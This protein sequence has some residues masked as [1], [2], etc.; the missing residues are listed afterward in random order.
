MGLLTVKKQVSQLL[1]E[2]GPLVEARFVAENGLAAKEMSATPGEEPT[3]ELNDLV[4]KLLAWP[5]PRVLQALFSLLCHNDPLLRWRTVSVMG[6]LVA[7]LANNNKEAARVVMRRLMWSLND[8]SGGIGWGAPEAI[9]ACLVYH[10]QLADEY[11]HILVSF[12]REDG[13]FLEYPPLQQGLMW[14]VGRLAQVRPQLLEKKRA[15]HYLLPYLDSPDATVR[16]LAARALG[17]L[18][19][20]SATPAL[21]LLL[22]QSQ[23]LVFYQH[24]RLLTATVDELVAAA[25]ARIK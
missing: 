9:A 17:L 20:G 2:V 3:A 16:G 8:E 1:V 15:S 19:A 14:G 22:G 24:P 21:R 23:S 10:A 7:D 4:A 18:R 13:A 6:P 25:L 5:R 12:M 11:T